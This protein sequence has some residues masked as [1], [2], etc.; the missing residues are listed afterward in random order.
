MEKKVG[1]KRS[2]LNEGFMTSV[3][4]MIGYEV[5]LQSWRKEL[6]DE[7]L[8]DGSEISFVMTDCHNKISLDFSIETKESMRNALHKLN[9]II[10]V[11]ESMK[12]DLK[13]ARKEIRKA[14]EKLK[15][16]EE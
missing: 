4:S 14:Q 12:A 8:C 3:S 10:E 7:N 11:C 1:F 13:S 9:T 5:K 6:I 2:F 15:E 16:L